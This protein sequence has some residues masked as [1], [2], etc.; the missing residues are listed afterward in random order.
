MTGLKAKT[1]FIFNRLKH[2][3][4]PE[5]IHRLEQAGVI[6]YLKLG[7]KKLI[8]IH[9]GLGGLKPIALPMIVGVVDDGEVQE[10]LTGKRYTLNCD[11]DSF[12][13]RAVWEPARLQHVYKL[14][15]FGGRDINSSPSPWPSPTGG[16]GIKTQGSIARSIAAQP[17]IDT[18]TQST[19]NLNVSNNVA[20]SAHLYA[21]N[22]VLSWIKE[23]PF[24][25]GSHYASAMECG[26]RIPVFIYALLWLPNLTEADRR[27]IAS[28]IYEHAWLIYRKLSLHSSLGNHTICE[29]VGLIYAGGLFESTAEGK[30]WL[31]KG[32][33]LL[34]TEI[35]H[36]ILDD[37]GPAEQSLNYHRF[38]LDLYW[39]AIGFLELNGL[40]DCTA[41]KKRLNMGEHF[42]AA[43]IDKSGCF[44]AIGDSDDGHAL[45]PGLR[46]ERPP[47]TIPK[48]TCQVFPEAGYTI[49]RGEKGC[50][51]VFDHGP[52]GMA[53]LYNHGHAD[54]LAIML[55]IDDRPLLVD[56]GTFRYNGAPAWRRYFKSTRAHNTVCV[57]SLDQAVQETGFI[58][59]HPYTV[60]GYDVKETSVGISVQA[61]HNGYARLKGPVEH[62]RVIRYEHGRFTINDTFDGEGIHD[63]ELN[64]HLHPDA[65]ATHQGNE[66]SIRNG[67][68]EC[69]I[70][71]EGGDEFQLKKGQID[72]I[73]GW[74]SPAYGIK[75]PA[76]V[77]SCRK[78]GNPQEMS[79]TTVIKV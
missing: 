29:S 44:P 57:D 33:H 3:T 26:L 67:D 12:D 53:P 37:G 34:D 8:G 65:E 73:L 66:W 24:L 31:S 52:L 30:Q 27:K 75:V 18:Q 74:Y 2:L 45:A 71:L 5:A 35:K 62:K 64:F 76:G 21:R 43:F 36:Q 56:P 32:I 28:A 51:L 4:L 42:L 22:E 6:L 47:A 38:V 77:L 68:A 69:T 70:N 23:N 46:P 79:F 25:K 78:K 19:E 58:W 50:R 15:F 61:K 39:M 49:L 9:A 11:T 41:W 72:P 54:A 48:K 7:G 60:D 10:I 40:Q 1:R 13:I 20:G 63:F 16:E 17:E 14:L 55:N 59:S